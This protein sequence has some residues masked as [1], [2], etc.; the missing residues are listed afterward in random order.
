MTRA[1]STLPLLESGQFLI[2]GDEQ[3][4]PR[5][6]YIR[7]YPL[8]LIISFGVGFA[9]YSIRAVQSQSR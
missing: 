2:E 3:E 8:G 7:P 6:W 9:Y 4:R 5:Q 1:F